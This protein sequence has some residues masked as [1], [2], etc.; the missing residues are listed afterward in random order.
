MKTNNWIVLSFFSLFLSCTS[1]T[2]KPMDEPAE[3]TLM[4]FDAPAV[5][6]EKVSQEFEKHSNKKLKQ[7][8]KTADISLRFVQ[9]SDLYELKNQVKKE[10]KQ[11]GGY[12]QFEKMVKEE[13]VQK[14]RMVLRLP[15]SRFDRFTKTIQ[16]QNGEVIGH[17][18]TID[19]VSEEYYDLETRIR[20]KELY[21]ER[22]RDLLK[23][24]KNVKEVLE[25]E[26]QIRVLMEELE[27]SKSRHEY[28]ASQVAESTVYLTLEHEFEKQ[29]TVEKGFFSQCF[30]AIAAGWKSVVQFFYAIL[31]IWP[32][33][34]M[35][36]FGFI[37]FKRWNRRRKMN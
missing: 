7:L 17:K 21:V 16:H 24:A 33:L 10:L 1:R 28:L 18:I 20:N 8:I 19:D 5:E 12:I 9:L 4:S 11:I 31:E 15:A 13:N 36:F 30:D 34:I 32:Y 6:E 27:S 14:E 3:M 25:I 29:V 2:E 37:G 26:E 35:L 23:Q 22:Y